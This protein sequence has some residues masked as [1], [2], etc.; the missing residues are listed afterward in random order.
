LCKKPFTL[1]DYLPAETKNQVIIIHQIP[2]NYA[3]TGKVDEDEYK[4]VALLS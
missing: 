1:D 4:G 3:I 2:E